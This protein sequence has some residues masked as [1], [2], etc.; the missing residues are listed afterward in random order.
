MAIIKCP[1]CG[2]AISDKAKVCPGCGVPII[3]D[4][5]SPSRSG[6]V[7]QN[8]LRVQGKVGMDV[9]ELKCPYCGTPLGSKDM[10]SSGWAHCPSCD[11]NVALQGINEQFRDEGIVE[12][13]LPFGVTREEFHLRCMNEMMKVA[14]ED[15]FSKLNGFSVTKKYIWVREF[16]GGQKRQIFATDSFG[17]KCLKLLNNNHDVV[18]HDVYLKWWPVNNM[19]IYSTELTGDTTLVPKEWTAKDIKHKYNTS[20]DSDGLNANDAYYCVPV[21]EEIFE[22]NG[23]RYEFYGVGTKGIPACAWGNG[24]PV[25]ETLNSSPKF[26]DGTPFVITAVIIGVIVLAILVID[27]FSGGFWSGL[28]KLIIFGVIG[29]FA[30]IIVVPIAISP[31]AALDAIIRTSVNRK[32]KRAFLNRFNEIQSRKQSEAKNLH[33]LN[34]TYTLPDIKIP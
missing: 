34:L 29:Y 30:G 21:M 5:S 31:F 2:K 13:I 27:C 7:S 4:T 32:R 8:P 1:E 33:N 12:W 10:V 6:M 11:N 19:Q 22:Y 28:F 9:H 24:K 3:D 26:Y 17:Q 25:D 20:Q 16:G 15:F 18:N 14:P 23:K